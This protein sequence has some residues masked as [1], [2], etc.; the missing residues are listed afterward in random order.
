MF[1]GLFW[2]VTC[3]CGAVALG[4]GGSPTALTAPEPA[5]AGAPSSAAG[6]SAEAHGVG[7]VGSSGA[8]GED[9]AL[10][11]GSGAAGSSGVSGRDAALAGSGAAGSSG[12]SG[13]DAAAPPQ[14]QRLPCDVASVIARQC[15]SCHGVPLNLGA[16]L[17]LVTWSDLHRPGVSDPSKKVYELAA[18]RVQDTTRPMPPKMNGKL[19]VSDRTLLVDWCAHGAPALPNDASECP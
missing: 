11:G 6:R 12:A 5:E 4:C 1:R 8:G 14:L 9:P 16:P 2:I 13:S 7:A 17:S 15:H 19:A 3:A 18:V 10:A